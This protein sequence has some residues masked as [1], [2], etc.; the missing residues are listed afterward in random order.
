[1]NLPDPRF[2]LFDQTPPVL[3][4]AFSFLEPPQEPGVEDPLEGLSVD[5][6][7]AIV[8][9]E[10][11][12]KETKYSLHLTCFIPLSSS[13]SS[14]SSSGSSFC[15]FSVK[16]FLSAQGKWV[17][18]DESVSLQHNHGPFPEEDLPKQEYIPKALTVFIAEQMAQGWRSKVIMD[19]AVQRFGMNISVEDFAKIEP[20]FPPTKSRRELGHFADTLHF[21]RFT[22]SIL[23]DK[24]VLIN[25]QTLNDYKDAGDQINKRR[26]KAAFWMSPMEKVVFEMNHIGLFANVVCDLPES[27]LDFIL[28]S[29][30]GPTR[31]I[32]AVGF[33]VIQN[34]SLE[35]FRSVFQQ[36]KA[37]CPKEMNEL[38]WITTDLNENF[39]Q[40]ASEAIEGTDCFHLDAPWM[41]CNELEKKTT[42]AERLK[43]KT[44]IH[45]LHFA[46]TE[47]SIAET[48]QRIQTLLKDDKL[49]AIV[50]ENERKL[51][52]LYQWQQG[53]MLMGCTS[54]SHPKM[55]FPQIKKP[56]CDGM[57]LCNFVDTINRY[58]G[59]ELFSMQ[60][61]LAESE[62][63][64]RT[65]RDDPIRSA[66][67][68][69][70]AGP[71]LK[72][73]DREWNGVDLASFL[74]KER[75]MTIAAS[76]SREGVYECNC[77]FFVELKLPCR[78]IYEKIL[79]HPR[80]RSRNKLDYLSILTQCTHPLYL[81][82]KDYSSIFELSMRYLPM[83]ALYSNSIRVFDA[84][85]KRI[86]YPVLFDH[87]IRL[88][89]DEK[90]F[91][92]DMVISKDE[93]YR[94][95]LTRSYDTPENFNDIKLLNNH[96]RVLPPVPLSRPV[97]A[98]TSSPDSHAS[99]SSLTVSQKTNSSRRVAKSSP[100]RSSPK[101]VS[102]RNATKS[103]SSRR[104]HRTTSKPMSSI[105]VLSDAEEIGDDE[106]DD[107]EETAT[108]LDPEE[109]QR[110][111]E[112]IERRC[113]E[114]TSKESSLSTSSSSSSSLVTTETNGGSGM[115]FDIGDYE[116]EDG[117]EGEDEEVYN[118]EKILASKTSEGIKWY[119]VKWEGYKTPTW[120]KR[121]DFADDLLPDSFDRKETSVAPAKRGPGRPRKTT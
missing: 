89:C 84:N 76:V 27:D 8:I 82:I 112:E 26:V 97:D 95:S 22:Y 72:L 109:I 108:E 15:P 66:L 92:S 36:M 96:R 65:I 50:E 99:S 51:C 77:L 34:K 70:I 120:I 32:L 13:S 91:F 19:M 54:A 67:C 105:Q 106:E 63:T 87:E 24:D 20:K 18:D 116:I 21:H 28:F 110:Q 83:A 88:L 6:R 102:D 49:F 38:Q 69:L 74:T 118:V 4:D 3:L 64:P 9:H 17:L 46:D 62:N 94:D 117:E 113:R 33:A 98:A 41:I 30:F 37:L 104:S 100:A 39:V 7:R 23:D 52:R 121:E 103:V 57:N 42:S 10:Q 47:E 86:T 101:K 85:G 31:N 80:A 48:K 53:K 58:W 55:R 40:A 35:C 59:T 45:D 114:R 73:V 119:K 43:I 111:V 2:V 29:T 60:L 14:S 71:V 90:M 16:F 5:E 1:M 44:L 25:R 81:T 115:T 68:G 93:P 61:K 56:L 12:K 11:R 107:E 79:N 75:G 78:H